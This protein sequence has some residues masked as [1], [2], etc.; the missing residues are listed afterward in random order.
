VRLRANR[1][2]SFRSPALFEL[3]LADQTGFRG[4]R[5]IDPCINWGAAV[6]DG[7]IPQRV[8]DNCA[9]HG[10][11]SDHSG[12]GP[13]VTVVTGGGYGLLEA[14]RSRSSTV[15]VVWQPGFAD[16]SVS[17]DYFDIEV[18]DE[19]ARLGANQIVYNCYNS[20]FFPTDP[21]CDLFDR[22]GVNG[23]IGTV[24]DSY[25]NI[26]TQNNRGYDLALRY[27]APLKRGALT[28]ETQHTYQETNKVALFADTVVDENGQFGNPKWVG[29]LNVTADAGRWSYFWGAN[30][31]GSVSN[32]RSFGGNTSTYRG[33]SVRVV[34]DSGSVVYHTFSA[35]RSFDGDLTVRMGVA[36]AFNEKPPRVT[37]LN[38][39]ELETMGD[40]AFYSQYDWVG[41]RFYLNLTKRF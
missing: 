21:L 34:L 30:V 13:G 35:A 15:G 18:K 38:L 24:N 17:L 22:G 37:T 5:A 33:E 36:N 11:A 7:S 4:Q 12:E 14:E 6:D 40:S 26:A 31:I 32:E 25:I 8:A 28:V 39:G 2:T 27:R 23:N 16:L 10:V 20:E 9:A 1:G 29:R 3:Y 41:R 19:V